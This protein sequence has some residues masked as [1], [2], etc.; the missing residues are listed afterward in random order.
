MQGNLI[1]GGIECCGDLIAP[2]PGELMI[3][4]PN[5]FF[6]VPGANGNAPVPQQLSD[7]PYVDIEV[8]PNWSV[9]L[10]G[11]AQRWV[12][13][14]RGD[15]RLEKW[16]DHLAFAEDDGSSTPFSNSVV[17]DVAV[18][19]KP[20]KN[21][22]AASVREGITDTH[23]L[24]INETSEVDAGSWV[25]V[26]GKVSKITHWSLSFGDDCLLY[27]GGVHGYV[28]YN[29]ETGNVDPESPSYPHDKYYVSG[30]DLYSAYVG[31]GPV[32]RVVA[33]ENGA[34]ALVGSRIGLFGANEPWNAR[35]KPYWTKLNDGL[36]GSNI[37]EMMVDQVSGNLLISVSANSTKPK[38][39]R[40]R[41]R[42][43]RN[44]YTYYFCGYTYNYSG[45]LYRSASPL[46]ANQ[47]IGGAGLPF[48]LSLS[49]GIEVD[50]SGGLIVGEDA[51]R[52]SPL[53]QVNT[54]EST[55]S[56]WDTTTT[57]PQEVAR[58]RVG[59]PSGECVGNTSPFTNGC[60]VPS[61]VAVDNVGD[62][63]VA[64]VGYGMQ[65]T[66]TKIAGDRSRCVDRDNDGQTNTTSID[67]TALPYTM[68]ND[69]NVIGDECVLWT[70]N[71]GG[72][73]QLLRSI[74]IGLGDSEHP[75]G[76][77][78]VGSYGDRKL[79]RLNPKTGTALNVHNLDIEPFGSVLLGDKLYISTLGN[80][81]IQVVDIKGAGTVS[82]LTAPPADLI[83]DCS[84]DNSYG[85]GADS[86]GRVWLSGWD[87]PYALGYIPGEN[88]WCRVNI[89]GGRKV[90]RG[91]SGDG[92]GRVWA[93]LGGDGQSYLAHWSAASCAAGSQ[94]TLGR[95]NIVPGPWGALGP[96]GVNPDA[97][98][99]LWLSHYLSPVLMSV[100]TKDG[101]ATQAW[102]T[103]PVYSFADSTG[104]IRRKSIGEGS[105]QHDFQ[106]PCEN[107]VRWGLFSWEADVPEGAELRFSV[108]GASTIEKLTEAT[109]I[110]FTLGAVSPQPMQ[111]ILD[112]GN[113]GGIEILHDYIR[114]RADMR[115]APDGS[116]PVLKNF[117][118]AW[119]CL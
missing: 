8:S 59:L 112:S 96:T 38:Y 87:C 46:L 69:P 7:E 21:L 76:Y 13:A 71:V 111:S 100:D 22:V 58:Y 65:G 30:V 107:G 44:R 108:K 39:C 2:S 40:R 109:A 99:K 85:I 102:Q 106:K 78:W 35:V 68:P 60:N 81:S 31:S 117:S 33:F 41:D 6:Y 105:F 27:I 98:G 89:P 20:G 51:L 86:E 74:S 75:D 50:A 42:R 73:G 14:V 53:W 119:E 67:G 24:Y 80:A 37:T 26:Q 101:N 4:A 25:A 9:P 94:T 48:D 93:A 113:P 118:V 3:A 61:R 55:V 11:E 82:P 77:P 19:K 66:V 43:R 79:Y 5:G 12:L 16:P 84:I 95:G 88:A 23:K 70:A 83:A 45:G 110:P 28:V 29:H 18:C 91:I 15:G 116:S 52:A 17:E 72:P 36:G 114:V 63:Y 56:R 57:P 47:K 97:D 64:S 92:N 32:R 10:V 34:P 90:G 103:S 49:N 54:L 62:V 115:L 104:V 1:G